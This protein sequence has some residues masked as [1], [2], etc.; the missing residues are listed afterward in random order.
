MFKVITKKK[1]VISDS[2]ALFFTSSRDH[3]VS[4]SMGFLLVFLI[5]L[6][7]LHALM[8]TITGTTDF[9]LY[10]MMKDAV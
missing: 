9:D 6:L 7:K 3:W 10:G 8:L 1:A 4:D 2:L 5:F